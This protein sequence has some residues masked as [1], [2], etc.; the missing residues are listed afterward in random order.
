MVAHSWQIRDSTPSYKDYSVLLEVMS[1]SRYIS[2][3]F[4]PIRKPDP[5][6]LS[7]GRVRF[8]RGYR[9]DLQAYTSFLRIAS[10]YLIGSV[11]QRVK[12]V[13]QSRRFRL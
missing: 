9:S 1:F 10:S 3:N 4:D 2:G 12:G 7:E 5:R 11:C 13:T 8:L 6:H